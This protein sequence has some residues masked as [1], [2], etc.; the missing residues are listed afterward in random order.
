RSHRHGIARARRT[1]RNRARQCDKQGPDAHKNP[2]FGVSLNARGVTERQQ[3]RRM[4]L[5]VGISPTKKLKTSV[6]TAPH[7]QRKARQHWPQKYA[8]VVI[9]GFGSYPDRPTKR[10]TSAATNCGLASLIRSPR[11]RAAESTSVNR[12][13]S[14]W[15]S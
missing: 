1:V 9:V 13:R 11:R 10:R 4:T 7:R 14:P 6:P 3:R 2:R 12:L 8:R 5:L 15:Q